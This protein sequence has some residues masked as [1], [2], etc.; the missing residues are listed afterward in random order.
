MEKTVLTLAAV[1]LTALLLLSACSG[2]A[3]EPGGEPVGMPNPLHETDEDGLAAAVG[4]PLPAPEGAEELRWS[5]IELSGDKPIA[6]M[7]FTLDGRR[8]YLRAQAASSLEAEDISG[9]YFDWTESGEAEVAYCPAVWHTNGEAGYIAW[10]DAVPGIVYNL[11]M[12]EGA[13]AELLIAAAN[14]V[15]VPVQGSV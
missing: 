8:Y 7:N 9:L 11:G 4:I 13:S 10:I 1:L 2:A 5:W 3:G 15:F 14:A 12:T 6:Q